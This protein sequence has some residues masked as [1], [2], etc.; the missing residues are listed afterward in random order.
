VNR[1]ERDGQASR[2]GVSAD[3]LR[4]EL[5]ALAAGTAVLVGAGGW[6]GW[7][8]GQLI[9]MPIGMFGGLLIALA[10]LVAVF[11]S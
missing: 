10:L 2:A 4:S 5:P 6:L 8:A 11:R 7:T 9:G 3:E 1:T